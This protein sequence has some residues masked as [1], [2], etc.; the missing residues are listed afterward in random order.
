MLKMISLRIKE[1]QLRKLAEIGKQQDRPVSWLIRKAVDDFIE[2]Q[3]KG[4]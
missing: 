4:K 1:Q 3:R 2:R